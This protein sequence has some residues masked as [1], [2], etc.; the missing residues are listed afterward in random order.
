MMPVY[1]CIVRISSSASE[2]VLVLGDS[3]TF[4]WLLKDADTYVAH[5]Q[6][7]IDT[8]YGI[9]RFE[10]INAGHG[11]WGASDYVRYYE[12]YG[13]DLDISAVLIFLN[14]DDIGR[15]LRAGQYSIDEGSAKLKQR[16]GVRSNCLIPYLA[17]HGC[18]TTPICFKL[19]AISRLDIMRLL[20]RVTLLLD[21]LRLGIS[22]S[23]RP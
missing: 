17:T 15:S 19:V 7:R 6:R 16:Y 2:R 11:G 4:G 5:L 8:H 13:A 18:C 12:D 21:L 20:S 22:I 9:G 3:F 10:L 14:T 1:L 23:G